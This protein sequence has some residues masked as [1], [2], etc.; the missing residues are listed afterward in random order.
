MF[1]SC[2]FR[3]WLHFTSLANLIWDLQVS[4]SSSNWKSMIVVISIEGAYKGLHRL[5]AMGKIF[6]G[7]T[8]GL[9]NVLRGTA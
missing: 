9:P 4:L 5:M 1:T 8:V 7:R 2:Y 3:S 6:V